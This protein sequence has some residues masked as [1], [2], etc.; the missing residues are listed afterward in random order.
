MLMAT[1]PLNRKRN[2]AWYTLPDMFRNKY[3]QVI[4]GFTKE[5]LVSK[6]YLTQLEVFD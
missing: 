2:S 4:I 3:Y 1:K 6:Q 5:I